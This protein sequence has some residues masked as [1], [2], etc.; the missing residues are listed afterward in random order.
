VT[1]NPSND[2][3]GDSLSPPL[4]P[5][6][7][8]LRETDEFASR[9]G[10]T[11]SPNSSKTVPIA[12]VAN[13]M[14]EGNLRSVDI[15]ACNQILWFSFFFDGTG[16]NR[17]FDE[18]KSQHSNVAK[19]FL[20]HKN[21][22]E[23]KG[24]YRVYIP[25]VGTRFKA[26]GDNGGSTLGLGTGK[27]GEARL[28]WAFTQFD[29]LLAPHVMRANN[30]AN[31]ILKINISVF[32]SSRGA[33]LARAFVSMFLENRCEISAASGMLKLAPGGYPVR[34]RFMGLFDTVASVGA[35][36]SSNNTS[37]AAAALGSVSMSIAHRL[38][39]SSL[40]DVTPVRLAFATGGLPGAD[41]AAGVYDGHSSW[42]AR[43][44]ISEYVEEVRHFVAAHE[45]R[46]SFP[47]ESV[48]IVE[49]GKCVR[50]AH[51]YETVY[52]GAHSD[53]G[54]SY[55][56]GD[57]GRSFSAIEKLGLIPLMHMFECAIAK[58]VPLIPRNSWKEARKRDFEIAKNLQKSYDYYLSKVGNKSSLG[59]LFH[60][61]LSL[62]Y[63]WRFYSIR[64]KR[65][66]YISEL[67]MI[68]KGNL[69]F[70][71]ERRPLVAA[72]ANL[73]T[74]KNAAK[75]ALEVV[76]AT[77]PG[78]VSRVFS[79]QSSSNWSKG[80]AE[81]T[82]AEAKLSD[83]EDRLLQAKARLD[84]IPNMD[85]FAAMLDLYDQ[86]LLADV[87][88]ILESMAASKT[89][90]FGDKNKVS[91]LRPHYKVLVAAYENE[92]IHDRGLR[93]QVII[94]FFEKYVHDS[95]AGFAKDAT[96][97]SDPRVVYVGGDTKLKISLTNQ[98]TDLRAA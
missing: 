12:D 78:L 44:K 3:V 25:G 53:V 22:D 85:M 28:V 11:T 63:A 61:N 21:D 51:F 56:P 26:I 20:A 47:L 19:L 60:A 33:A 64:R 80:Q 89:S 75:K 30:S 50:P 54:G 35:P 81:K 59:A 88:G 13:A 82:K 1:K 38:R 29:D 96:L 74:E 70:Q 93:D 73:E 90:F 2:R 91:D 76:R 48:S 83:A 65:E 92:Y 37:V 6:S 27:G 71:Q 79:G 62:Y 9:L 42:G 5:H 23:V 24:I 45:I 14:G 15:A 67:G 18:E 57:G 94:E 52:P 69:T 46:N 86:Q 7:R 55:R 32:G 43:M 77:N 34:V 66:G 4:Q 58:G 95:L 84:S 72:I 10:A 97:P 87:R 49:G 68:E 39:D 31:K 40:A 16:N 36:M 41:P 98:N 17:E 8:G